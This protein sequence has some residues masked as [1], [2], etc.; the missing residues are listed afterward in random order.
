V[1]DS[2]PNGSYQEL[3]IATKE[4]SNWQPHHNK[5]RIIIHTYFDKLDMR[6]SVRFI[7]LKVD[8]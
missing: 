3:M 8:G 4:H 5:S 1:E 2:I 6:I 7:T